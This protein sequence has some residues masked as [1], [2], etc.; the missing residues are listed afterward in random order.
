MKKNL[1][2]LLCLGLLMGVSGCSNDEVSGGSTDK[3]SE[4]KEEK[5][6]EKKVY[7]LDDVITYSEDGKELYTFKINSVKTTK[8]RNQFSD[9]KPEQVV[10]IDYT[11]ENIGSD[12]DVYVSGSSNFTV[13]DE[14]GNVCETY[15]A[16]ADKNPKET[17]KGAKCTA[18][19]AF[20]LLKKSS[21]IKIRFKESFGS[22]EANFELDIK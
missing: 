21:K 9:K 6:E 13:I 14:D 16:G 2:T 12:E 7:G 11:Y 19:E 18:D 20:G 4:Q 17:P 15:P 8:E 1:S 3:D 5:K 22:A 10:V